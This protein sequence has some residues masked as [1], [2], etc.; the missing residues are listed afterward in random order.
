MAAMNLNNMLENLKEDSG[1][2]KIISQL[3]ELRAGRNNVKS[4]ERCRGF[5]SCTI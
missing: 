2:K 3:S 5:S 4:A 1:E